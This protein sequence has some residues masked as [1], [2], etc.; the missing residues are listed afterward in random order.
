VLGAVKQFTRYQTNRCDNG[1]MKI[2]YDDD[3]DG[4]DDDS[5]LST[6]GQVRG[7]HMA[8]KAVRFAEYGADEWMDGCKRLTGLYPWDMNKIQVT[9]AWVEVLD[10]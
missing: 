5:C 3:E 2:S 6:L 1:A 10:L 4:D 8:V 7:V 9:R